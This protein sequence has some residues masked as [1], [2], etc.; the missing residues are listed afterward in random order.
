MGEIRVRMTISN[1][2]IHVF[3]EIVFFLRFDLCVV[4]CL[5]FHSGLRGLVSDQVKQIRLRRYTMLTR[6][7]LRTAFWSWLS[8][9]ITSSARVTVRQCK[10]PLTNVSNQK[11]G[12]VM[13]HDMLSI[14]QR[15]LSRM[16][17]FV[18]WSKVSELSEKRV[19]SCDPNSVMYKIKANFCRSEA[20]PV[21][22]RLGPKRSGMDR[23]LLGFF[24]YIYF[25]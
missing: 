17:V 18:E 9:F 11:P 6:Q 16:A 10:N 22:G 12:M 13:D 1:A 2:L 15:L 7:G 3:H 5:L 23:R 24:I 19:L 25:L 4:V 8:G 14:A 20:R 21:A